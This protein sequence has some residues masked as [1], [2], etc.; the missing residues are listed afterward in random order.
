MVRPLQGRYLY[1]TRS[2]DVVPGYL[3]WPFQGLMRNANKWRG[4][5][6]CTCNEG[7][8]EIVN[9]T[10]DAKELATQLE[11]T[12]RHFL[13]HAATGVAGIALTHL[14]NGELAAAVK[15]VLN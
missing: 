5:R 15:E 2:G 12:R 11:L 14:L 4:N 7:N 1:F 8:T 6:R 13:G 10:M 3:L 9:S